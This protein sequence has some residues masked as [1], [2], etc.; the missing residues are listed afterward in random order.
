MQKKKN[1]KV[2]KKKKSISV[3][4]RPDS[5][6]L[7]VRAKE[8]TGSYAK[9]AKTIMMRENQVFSNLTDEELVEYEKDIV[10]ASHAISDPRSEIVPETPED[11]KLLD[12]LTE[13]LKKLQEKGYNVGKVIKTG[14]KRAFG[15]RTKVGTITLPE[16]R[17]V[18]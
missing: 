5:F 9:G 11:E 2:T 10:E 18:A 17:K 14:A 1:K 8:L 4:F 15:N 16:D 12:N 6:P 13:S 7:L 3:S